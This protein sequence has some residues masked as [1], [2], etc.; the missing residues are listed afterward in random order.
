MEENEYRT[1]Y[2]SINQNR[3]VFE[4]AINSRRCA[5]SQAHRF[6]LADREGVA[7]QTDLASRRCSSF[8]TI[9]R[10]KACFALKLSR[11][12][13]PLPHTKEMKVQIGG[14]LGL[15]SL[16]NN[17]HNNTDTVEDIYRLLNEIIERY[18]SLDDLPFED[19]VKH[20]VNFDARRSLS[21]RLKDRH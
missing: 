5:C 3:C 14:A 16:L 21:N 2:H 4:K 7:C 8:L 17:Q 11:L 20:I 18:T 10:D 12:D 19:I 1:T 6:C 9:L 13:G 15:V